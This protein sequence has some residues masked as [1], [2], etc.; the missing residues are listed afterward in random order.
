MMKKFLVFS[1]LFIS[2]FSYAQLRNANWCFGD[3]AGINF[4]SG[5]P[6]PFA[7]GMDGRGSCASISD[8]SGQLLFYSYTRAGV[9]GNT[10]KVMNKNNASMQNGDLIVGQGWYQENTIINYPN[11]NNLYYLFSIGVTGASQFGLY[12]SIIDLNQDSG[13]GSVTQKNIQLRT[14]LAIDG[15]N[16]VKHA[17]GRDWWLIFRNYQT[18]NNDYYVYLITPD[19]IA[20]NSFQSVGDTN[21]TNGSNMQFDKNG[22]QIL[23]VNL[24][25]LIEVLRF[26]RCTGLISLNTVV[27]HEIFANPTYFGC[28]FSPSGRFIYVVSED[29]HNG[30]TNNSHLYQFDLEAPNVTASKTTIHIFTLPESPGQLKLAPDGKIYLSSAYTGGFIPYSDADRNYINENLS[31]INSPD[32]FGAAC[33]FTP[34]SFYLGGKR[35]Y[36]SLPNNPNYDLAP[37]SGSVCDSL[38]L[39]IEVVEY[40]GQDNIEIFPNP[41]YNKISFHP[42]N[43]SLEKI[44]I[45]VF[46]N[47]G[48]IVFVKETAMKDQ[49]IDLSKLTKGIYFLNAKSEKFSVTKKIVKM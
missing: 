28:E 3:S 16:V 19:S 11:H 25:G 17:N 14:E 9:A 8:S 44:S 27:E 33:D 18:Y 15:I 39:G 38:G 10:T 34:F 4:T 46:N 45:T 21:T 30:M 42:F 47:V 49:E 26:D 13:L 31:V 24:R 5:N 6:I 37:V 22:N 12:Y 20:L 40:T 35:T 29:Y 43:S 23:I 1:L 48:E 7:S 36:I 41:F 32:S 2:N